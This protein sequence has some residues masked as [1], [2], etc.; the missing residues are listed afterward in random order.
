METNTKILMGGE[1]IPYTKEIEASCKVR[2]LTKKHIIL[3]NKLVCEHYEQNHGLTN[4]TALDES[5]GFGRSIQ[6]SLTIAK[7]KPFKN[8]NTIT[9]V[10]LM[11]YRNIYEFEENFKTTIESFVKNCLTEGGF[12]K[13]TFDILAQVEK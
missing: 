6:R 4:E 8:G 3:L 1:I 11:Y 13:H 5:I 9:A 7:E 10:M 12:E 2:P